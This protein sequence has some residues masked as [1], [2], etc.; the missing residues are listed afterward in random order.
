MGRGCGGR[1]DLEQH[2]ARWSTSG[3]EECTAWCREFRPPFRD[4]VA[5][6]GWSA[7]APSLAQA[8]ASPARSTPPGTGRCEGGGG[9][10]SVGTRRRTGATLFRSPPPV[11]GSG[12]GRYREFS[13][14]RMSLPVSP[15]PLRFHR[16]LHRLFF[17]W[18][19]RWRARKVVTRDDHE[20]KRQPF[21]LRRVELKCC[22]HA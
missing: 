19:V 5:R 12:L 20:G 18:G 13:W 6:V 2:H 22:A 15:P 4:P 10:S 3:P 1:T 21:S 16:I 7:V 9:S 11:P 8:V 17:P 14:L